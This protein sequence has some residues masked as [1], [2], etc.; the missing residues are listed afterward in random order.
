[1]GYRKK[2][3]S[4]SL[5][6]SGTFALI[7]LMAGLFMQ[8]PG[9]AVTGIRIATGKPD[10]DDRL[11]CCACA[12]QQLSPIMSHCLLLACT[13]FLDL[14]CS[15]AALWEVFVAGTFTA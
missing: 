10:P 4:A 14:T 5:I 3:S 15:V 8:N 1:M 11:H 7:L 6:S 2:G 12:P 9:Q 13:Q